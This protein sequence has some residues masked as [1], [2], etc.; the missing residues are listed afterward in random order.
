MN[1]WQAL[2][3]SAADAATADAPRYLVGVMSGTSAD[4]ADAAVVR[5]EGSAAKLVGFASEPFNAD[6]RRRVLEMSHGAGN[7]ETVSR[8]SVELSA[9]FA[10]AVTAAVAAAHLPD[11][12]GVLAVGCHGQTVSHTP[13]GIFPATLQLCDAASLA[14]RTRLPVVSNFRAADIA[15]GGQGAPLV[16]IA[17]WR[18]LTH[19]T[20]NRAVQ[21][22][23][24][25]ANVTY[26][27]ADG[28]ARDVIGFD[29]G[30]GNMLI[31]IAA[32][33]ATKGAAR[34]DKDGAM[35]ASGEVSPKLLA[36]LF[37]HP[38]LAKPPPKSAGREEFGEPFW[39][40]IPLQ[41]MAVRRG[42]AQVKSD[43]LATLT[44]FSAYSIADAYANFLPA[45]PDEVIVSGGG[46]ANP[47]LLGFL[48]EKLSPIPVVTADEMGIVSQAREAVTFAVLADLTLRG[49]LTTLPNVTGASRAAVSGS[50][51]LPP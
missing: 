49:E 16:P 32:S 51:T 31:D 48:R 24:G 21:N 37:T 26:L 7:A 17:D 33:W 40:Q 6:L 5:F 4:G 3:N 44:A 28:A 47:I 23:G 29:T 42:M 25:I 36:W 34:Y 39:R 22:I 18:L 30:A 9:R 41:T 43:V 2:F 35:A 45:L 12:A 1:R 50:V 20:K 19:P 13:H 11:G 15:L 38:F 46:A 10:S 8:L 27:P 14:H